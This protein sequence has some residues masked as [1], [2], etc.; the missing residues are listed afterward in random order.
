MNVDSNT[1]H[2]GEKI[3]LARNTKGF[4]LLD[5]A[6]RVDCSESFLSKVE[7][8]KAKPSLDLLVRLSKELGTSIGFLCDQSS[9]PHKVVMRSGERMAIG[10]KSP[11][12]GAGEYMECLTS[13]DDAG[14]LFG[15]IHVIEPKGG[16]E[17]T[18]VHEGEEIGYVIEGTLALKI[19]GEDYLLHKD[20]SFFFKSSLE[21]SYRNP[22]DKQT[23]VV[24]VSAP[25]GT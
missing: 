20:D 25:I 3:R 12:A 15:T 1:P 21:H 10:I 2:L 5:L 4:S 22:T 19:D 14:Y 13:I 9:K 11:K 16:C 18:Y 8:S 6:S 17:G 24:W 7:N 23:R